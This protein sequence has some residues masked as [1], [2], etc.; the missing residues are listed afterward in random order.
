MK[1]L[2]S[3]FALLLVSVLLL[4]CLNAPEPAPVPNTTTI[5]QNQNPIPVTQVNITKVETTPTV[6]EMSGGEPN[7]DS[8][9]NVYLKDSPGVVTN[10][11]LQITKVAVID[12]SGKATVLYAGN[13]K[14]DL[15]NRITSVIG[16]GKI[17]K[18]RYKTIVVEI[19]DTVKV[20]DTTGTR[21]AKVL[22]KKFTAT[23]DYLMLSG[24]TVNAV[25]DVTLFN[26]VQIDSHKNYGFKPAEFA[27]LDLQEKEGVNVKPLGVLTADEEKELKIQHNMPSDVKDVPVLN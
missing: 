13:K 23:I 10:V 4:G 15:N 12:T 14:V 27:Y 9:F 2:T 22:R 16:S 21:D 5:Q 7:G 25:L 8:A 3:I 20:T 6:T 26:A 17:Y 19:A 24:N 11:E 1:K 18:G